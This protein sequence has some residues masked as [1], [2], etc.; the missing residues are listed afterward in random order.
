[1][2]KKPRDLPSYKAYKK[3]IDEHRKI[4]YA[5]GNKEKYE[6]KFWIDNDI[7]WRE[8]DSYTRK[9]I[10]SNLQAKVEKGIV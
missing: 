10:L 4:Y 5:A 8:L 3:L 6:L 2:A 7:S 1:M 9:S